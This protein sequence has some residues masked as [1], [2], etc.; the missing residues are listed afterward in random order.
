MVKN[1]LRIGR[2]VSERDEAHFSPDLQ[3]RT[4]RFP[5]IT[6]GCQV[7]GPIENPGHTFPQMSKSKLIRLFE[8]NDPGERWWKFQDEVRSLLDRYPDLK[9]LGGP[10]LDAFEEGI[11]D[12]SAALAEIAEAVF[13]DR[14]PDD[15]IA[16]RRADGGN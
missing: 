1:H 15:E 5:C 2:L 3:V 10:D 13:R 4:C 9:G 8:S 14:D 11:G 7:P 6:N 16:K 12:L